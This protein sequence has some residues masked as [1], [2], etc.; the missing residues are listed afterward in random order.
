MKNGTESEK[1]GSG[2]LWKKK[3]KNGKVFL[4][5]NVFIKCK[6]GSIHELHMNVFQN[7]FVTKFNLGSE[8]IPD[9]SVFVYTAKK[10]I[11]AQSEDEKKD[12]NSSII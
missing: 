6:D 12:E 4:S 7:D 10:G 5:G 8:R 3:A 11:S 1:I 9:F 2:A